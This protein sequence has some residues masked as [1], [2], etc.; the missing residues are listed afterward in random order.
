ML[1]L[2]TSGTPSVVV[3]GG[4]R[5]IGLSIAK[6]FARDGFDVL[7]VGRDR[8]A[9]AV[10]AEQIGYPVATEAGDAGRGHI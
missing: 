4:S 2:P 7:I 6:R 5:G 3:T 9:L 1:N 8:G 10:A